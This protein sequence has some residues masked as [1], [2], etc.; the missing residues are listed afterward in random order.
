MLQTD[1]N[2]MDNDSSP[3]RFERRD[4][5]RVSNPILSVEI[6]GKKYSTE[7]WSLSGL[8]LNGVP[9]GYE[10]DMPIEGIFGPVG[11]AEMCRFNGHIVRL[12]KN[13]MTTAI[14]LDEKSADVAA[15]LPLWVLKYGSR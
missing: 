11:S 4:A 10:P 8:L 14:E 12:S 2:H 9:P 13:M 15:L 6:M 5:F 3:S 7:N 1:I